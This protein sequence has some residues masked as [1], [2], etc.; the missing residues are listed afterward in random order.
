LTLHK[1]FLGAGAVTISSGDAAHNGISDGQMADVLPTIR[2][3][4][5]SSAAA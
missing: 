4:G 1:P 5:C 3:S 2:G